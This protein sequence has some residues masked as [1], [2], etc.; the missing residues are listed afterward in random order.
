MVSDQ[1]LYFYFEYH[2][3]ILALRLLVLDKEVCTDNSC[4]RA[5]VLAGLCTKGLANEN[6]SVLTQ[7]TYLIWIAIR[8]YFR[9]RCICRKKAVFLEK[10][11]EIGKTPNE[12]VVVQFICFQMHTPT[13]AYP[14][15]LLNGQFYKF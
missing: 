9:A 3:P 12:Q 5:S 2:A 10:K 6:A 13:F 4:K 14:I 1:F 7:A 15:A 11:F 8:V